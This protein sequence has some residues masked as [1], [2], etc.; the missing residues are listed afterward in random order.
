[1][2]ALDRNDTTE[3]D[4]ML[5]FLHDRFSGTDSEPLAACP[6][7]TATTSPSYAPT[8][9]ASRSF[10]SQMTPPNC[11]GPINTEPT[12]NTRGQNR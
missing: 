5:E 3:L 8:A 12:Q 9:P 2:S 10:S 7:P 4:E 1:M 6:A 11:S